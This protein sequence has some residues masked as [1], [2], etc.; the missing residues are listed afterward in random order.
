[1]FSDF[2]TFAQTNLKNTKQAY[3][4]ST[5]WRIFLAIMLS[6]VSDEIIRLFFYILSI[7]FNELDFK[8]L[9]LWTPNV[10]FKLLFTYLI[11][12]LKHQTTLVNKNNFKDRFKMQILQFFIIYF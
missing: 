12:L 8:T 10:V 5:L 3:L 2:E 6:I 9:R 11:H 1:M 4:R 7:C